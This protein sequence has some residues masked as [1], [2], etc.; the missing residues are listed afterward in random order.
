MT[1]RAVNTHVFP[2]QGEVCLIVIKTTR[3]PGRGGM[4][5][6][7]IMGKIV[8]YMVGIG[9]AGKIRLMTTIAIRRCVVIPIAMTIHAIRDRSMRAG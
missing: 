2:G 4:A 3:R 5:T 9:Y 7:A 8:R 6:Y 1:I